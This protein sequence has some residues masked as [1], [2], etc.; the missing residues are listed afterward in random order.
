[1]RPGP[2]GGY[3]YTG[4]TFRALTEQ[5][6]VRRACVLSVV[7]AAVTCL[8]AL[9]AGIVRFDGLMNTFYVILPYLALVIVCCV[10]GWN[11]VRLLA[12]GRRVREYVLVPCRRRVSRCFAAAAVACAVQ[13]AASLV[14]CFLSSFGDA[15][16]TALYF[17]LLALCA[18]A[19]LAGSALFRKVEWAKN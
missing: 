11:G 17:S 18:A 3:V 7:C 10:L 6:G 1:M 16:Q 13:A 9:G 8:C 19:S 15:L 12:G 5:T 4:A 14:F 2:G